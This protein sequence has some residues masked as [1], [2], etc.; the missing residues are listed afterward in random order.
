MLERGLVLVGTDSQNQP[1]KV[2]GLE[3]IVKLRLVL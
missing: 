1:G 2:I 3:A